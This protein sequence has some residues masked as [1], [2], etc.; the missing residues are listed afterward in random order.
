MF[1]YTRYTSPPPI[2]Y[3]IPWATKDGIILIDS[4]RMQGEK[5]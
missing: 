3:P 1:S 2:K 4:K 5:K